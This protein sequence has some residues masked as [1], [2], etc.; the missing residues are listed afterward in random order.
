M[1]GKQV[2]SSPGATSWPSAVWQVILNSCTGGRGG[3]A[4]Q[5]L[6]TFLGLSVSK[7]ISAFCPNQK[8]GSCQCASG[9]HMTLPS[10]WDT[11]SQQGQPSGSESGS[12]FF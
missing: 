10:C 3:G 8:L 12:S 4:C 7:S 6:A 9:T 5:R 11:G 1:G 2:S